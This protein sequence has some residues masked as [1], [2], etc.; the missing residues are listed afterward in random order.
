MSVVTRFAPSPTGLLHVGNARA[1]LVNWLFA[2]AEGGVFV[3]RLDD[4]DQERS[5]EA[6]AQGIRDDLSWL[7]LDWTREERQSTRLERYGAAMERL[8]AAGRLYACYE[9]PEELA[10]K[11]KALLNA[12]RPPIYD[13]AALDLTDGDRTRLEAEGRAPHWRLKLLDGAIAWDDLVRGP[14]HFEAGNL[15]DPVLIRADGTPLYHLPSVV[16]DI[17]FQVTHVIRGEDHVDNTALHVQLFEALGATVPSFG[18]LA[19]LTDGEGKGL[20]KRLG[21]LGLADLRAAGVEALAL[22]A[23][24]ARIGTSRPVEPVADRETLVAGFDITTFG[25]AAAR[26][27]PEELMALSARTLHALPLRAVSDRLDALEVDGGDQAFWEAVRPNLERL[28]DAADW[29]AICR[30]PVTPLIEDTGFCETAA[31]LL[32]PEP[33]DADTWGAFTGAVKAAT[34]A[35]GKALFMPLRTALTGRERG[36]ELAVLLPLI[37]RDRAARRLRGE[38]A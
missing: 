22:A 10:L 13:R 2:C 37:G 7:G 9:T 4:T 20:S 30:G 31:G 1:A 11:R 3:L 21:S 23:Y 8:R 17:D 6:F 18:H 14:V 16:D 5:T 24:L 36:P 19:L 34:G 15:S 28:S 33:W 12:G 29:W 35:K 27:D 25:R 26:F 38:S 32:P